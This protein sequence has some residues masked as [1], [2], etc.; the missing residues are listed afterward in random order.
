[1][2]NNEYLINKSFS[3]YNRLTLAINNIV[4]IQNLCFGPDDL[5]GGLRLPFRHLLVLLDVLQLPAGWPEIP[6]GQA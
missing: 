5:Y 3:T 2:M 1:M 6:D 4:G